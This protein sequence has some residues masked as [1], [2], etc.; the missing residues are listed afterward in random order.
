M[1]VYKTK[2]A[3]RKAWDNA[4]TVDPKVP[5]SIDIELASLCNLACPF[6]YWGESEFQE[7][8]KKSD[9]DGNALKRFMPMGMAKRII[10]EAAY[11]GVPALKMN[12]RGESTLHKDFSEIV[13]YAASKN[14][15]H[16]ILVNTNANC[17]EKAIPGL[18]AAT[19]VMV[20]LDSLD[21]DRYLRMRVGG[22]MVTAI[23]IIH[24]L[25][26]R[27]HPDLWVRRVVTEENKDEKFI[28]A[29]KMVFCEDI[30]VSEHFCF[31]RNRALN[32]S[33]HGEDA[34]RWERTYCGY[35][36]QRLLITSSGNFLP[37]CVD[38]REEMILGNFKHDSIAQVW[39]SKDLSSLRDELRN[40]KLFSSICQKCTSYLAYKRP[41]RKFVQDVL[42]EAKI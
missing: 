29:C 5:L 7:E 18:M 17:S 37:C 9:K 6:C 4:F 1:S 38:W 23:F 21:P 30:K 39:E 26:K 8:M 41:E 16:E 25:R 22:D 15:F 10:D 24:S 3:Y 42:G 33:V 36:S 28:T 11:L 20:S 2:E 19:K 34:V 27:K 13:Q 31:D 35:P 14:A 32:A 40:D 12:G